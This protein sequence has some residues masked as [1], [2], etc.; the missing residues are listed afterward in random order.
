AHRQMEDTKK[1]PRRWISGASMNRRLVR[2][3]FRIA[4]AALALSEASVMLPALQAAS[5]SFTSEAA[6]VMS[7]RGAWAAAV[8]PV[9]VRGAWTSWLPRGAWTFWLPRGAW[10]S[11][12]PRGAC[13][14]WLPRGAWTFWLPRGACTSWLPRGA[15]TAWLPRGAWPF[16]CP[17]RAAR[18]SF[19]R[20]ASLDRRRP[21]AHRAV[22][23]P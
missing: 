16:W 6:F 1:R 17:G 13:T 15:W 12:L 22:R 9:L 7:V 21:A 23:P 20:W 2:Y 11:W 5:A 3:Y 4:S 10:T 18:A 19:A 14:S 8:A